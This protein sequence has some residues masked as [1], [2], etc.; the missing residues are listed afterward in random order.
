VLVFPHD[1]SPDGRTALYG[2]SADPNVIWAVPVRGGAPRAV[3]RGTSTVNHP[4]FSPNG[5]WIAYAGDEA[6]RPEVLVVPYP[7]A[8]GRWQVS[9]AGGF[10]PR[11]RGDGRELYYLDPRGNLM[12]AE[13][14]AGERFSSR[15]PRQLFA[16][17]IDNPSPYVPDYAVVPDGSRFLLRLPAE[18]HRPPELKLVLGWRALLR[19]GPGPAL[20]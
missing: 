14:T 5:R 10:Q 13:V 17:G 18:G 20:R 1:W 4:V 12:A 6:G 15:P 7:P 3:V 8:E 16:T 2:T 11:W 9:I 19:D